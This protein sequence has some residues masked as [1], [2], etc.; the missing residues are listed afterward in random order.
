VALI[1]LALMVI[2]RG[3]PFFMQRRPGYRGSTFR[4]LKLRTLP[5]TTPT[6][7]SKL[8]LDFDG[9]GL[10]WL[11]RVLRRTHLDE[12]P[13]LFLVPLGSM[14]LVGPRPRLPDTV[15][16]V[17]HRFDAVRRSVRPGCTGLWQISVASDTVSTG[18][19]RFDLAYVQRASIRLDLWIL[20]RTVTN[21]VGLTKPVDLSDV[22]GWLLGSGLV[23]TPTVEYP[24][25]PQIAE[26]DAVFERAPRPA[27]VSMTEAA[28]G[29]MLYQDLP[30]FPVLAEVAELP[31]SV[32]AT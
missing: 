2:H 19:P 13:Q 6:Y 16:G 3:N 28:E 18:A 21:V 1:A 22:P 15:E 30:P 7:V 26:G 32:P 9:M 24:S 11:C 31:E 12:L 14:S 10:Q 17:D 25:S 5:R 4:I 23:E 29:S 8:D 20:I 27:V